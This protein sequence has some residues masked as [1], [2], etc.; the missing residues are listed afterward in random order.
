[1]TNS[2]IHRYFAPASTGNFSVGFDLLGVAFEPLPVGSAEPE[3]LGDV[4]EILAEQSELSLHISGRYRH[5]LPA[6]RSDNLVLSCFYAFEQAVGKPLPRLA[7]HLQKNLPVGSG[8]GSSAC[9]IVVA[10]YAFNDYFGQPLTQLQLLQLMA[11]AEGGVSG[12][13]HYDNVAPS[14][15]G[16]LQLMLPGSEQLSRTLPWFSH[17][18]VVLSYPGTVLS[19]RAARAVLPA[20]LSLADSISF[21]GMLSRFIS[22]LYCQDEAEAVAALQDLVAEPARTPLIPELPALRHELTAKGVLHLGISGAGPTLFALCP[23]DDTATVTAAYL[24]QHYAKNA[25]A[26]THICQLSA[27]GARAL[28]KQAA[29][30]G[31]RI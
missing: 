20:Q 6:D 5:Q 2:T 30:N 3:L 26:C 18:R 21:A 17:W 13:V 29:T 31:Q 1:M 11:E 25:D 14:L 28:P 9:S 12:S 24:Q 10:C 4:L 16:G 27:A 22:A 7:L 23:D 8:L 19:T 15:L